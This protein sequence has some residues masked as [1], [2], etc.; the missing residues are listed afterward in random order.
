MAGCI[1]L[2]IALACDSGPTEPSP[3]LPKV[4]VSTTLSRH[5]SSGEVL[6]PASV[7][8]SPAQVTVDIAEWFPSGGFLLRDVHVQFQR[9]AAAGSH[10]LISLNMETR[11]TSGID[12]TWRKDHRITVSQLPA[13][14]YRLIVVR[15]DPEILPSLHPYGNPRVPIDA[16]L[17]VP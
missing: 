17:D 9:P 11:T 13:G 5:L 2:G 1:I 12:A 6:P 4:T 7:T 15:F 8:T 14:T 10:G 3:T 16:T